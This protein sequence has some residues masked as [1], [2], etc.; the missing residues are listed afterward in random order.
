MTK[1]HVLLYSQRIQQQSWRQKRIFKKC[2]GVGKIARGYDD[3][4]FSG[5]EASNNTM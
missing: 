5:T 2:K 3:A 1:G 4:S